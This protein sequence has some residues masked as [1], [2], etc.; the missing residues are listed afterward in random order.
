MKKILISVA[1]TISVFLIGCQ[2]PVSQNTNVLPAADADSLQINREKE[3]PDFI[4]TSK[5]TFYS[6]LSSFAGGNPEYYEDIVQLKG[7]YR[8][9]KLTYPCVEIRQTLNKKIVTYH[10][11]SNSHHSFLFKKHENY[12]LAKYFF[13]GDTAKYYYTYEY[14]LPKEA[15]C[16][17]YSNKECTWLSKI[18]VLSPTRHTI[19]LPAKNFT[20]SPV[21]SDMDAIRKNYSYKHET[22]LLEENNLTIVQSMRTSRERTEDMRNKR[23]YAKPEKKY[24]LQWW[25]TFGLLLHENKCRK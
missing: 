20:V 22:T 9:A 7:R 8:L 18:T 6:I 4:V 3:S 1:A 23:C 19:Y 14:V 13:M 5:D 25:E 2:Q 24:T 11:D 16:F 17:D 12:W 21:I 10:I 15:V